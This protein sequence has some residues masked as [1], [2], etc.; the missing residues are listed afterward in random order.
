VQRPSTTFACGS[1]SITCEDWSWQ[2]SSASANN[3]PYD[4]LSPSH[5]ISVGILAARA[6]GRRRENAKLIV[7]CV[8]R[9]AA[10]SAL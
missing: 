8:G 1:A 5:A 2:R 10:R 7:A 4:H 9:A 3:G 6:H